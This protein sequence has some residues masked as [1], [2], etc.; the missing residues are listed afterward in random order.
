MF[1]LASEILAIKI[2]SNVNIKGLEMNGMNTKVSTYADDTNFPLSPYAST[3]Q[4]LE[5]DLD[6]FST[7]SGLKP[8]YDKCTL[9]RIGSLKG[10]HFTLPCSLPIRWTDGPV[11]VLGIHIPKNMNDLTNI[12]IN[13]RINKVDKILQPWQGQYLTINGKITL[14]NS[15]IVSQFTHLFMS[16]PSP[17]EAFFK[18][19]E[20]KIFK[21]IWNNKPNKLKRVFLYNEYEQRGLK[22]LNLRALNLSL[23]ALVQKLYL[24]PSWFSSRLL[25]NVHPIYNSLFPFMQLQSKHYNVI[26]NAIFHNLYSF[27]KDAIKSWL[28]FQYYPPEQA[29]HFLQQML[30]FNSNILIDG[31]PV[32]WEN[33]SK[34][35]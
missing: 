18:A 27:L 24:N 35:I 20:Q 9:L 23:K 29:E 11:D 31:K 34:K 1:I 14:I 12:N 21:F 8:N 25:K 19:Y 22:L 33:M 2:R 15:L 30:W 10:T 28:H 17:G 13:N 26:E 7:L 32:F 3:L 16:L 6:F 4:A 5:T